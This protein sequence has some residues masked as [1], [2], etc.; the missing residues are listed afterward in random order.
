VA[1][2]QDADRLQAIEEDHPGNFLY[3]QGDCTD[4]EVLA[5]ANIQH[6]RGLVAAMASDK[7]NLYLVVTARQIN[8][9]VRIVARGSDLQVVEKLKKAGADT[10]VSPS[11]IGGMRMVSELIRPEVVR[12]LDVM[13]KDP[14]N[15]RIEEV[16]LPEG[17]RFH[18]QTVG[19][20]VERTADVSVLAVHTGKG[21]YIYN[22][23]DDF[24]LRQ[25]M[26]LVVLGPMD[27]VI[28]LRGLAAS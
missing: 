13:L 11:F 24:Q 18:G 28:R 15:Y 16:A 25:G 6:A 1:I 10:V 8:P 9:T 23:A 26:T 19:A 22:P 2:E 27:E 17:S 21:E 20:H 7:D 4:D 14:R 12:F 3:I 5:D